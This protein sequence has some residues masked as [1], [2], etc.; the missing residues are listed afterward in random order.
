MSALKVDKFGFIIEN[1][2]H[3]EYIESKAEKYQ[4]QY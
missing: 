2:S 1:Q 3:S 4:V